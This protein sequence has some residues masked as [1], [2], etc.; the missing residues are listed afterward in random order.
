MNKYDQQWIARYFDDC[1]DREWERWEKSPADQVKFHI[2]RYYLEKYVS[3]GDH[4]LEIG[5]GSGRFTQTLVNLGAKILVADI[6]S[7]QL[8][9]NRRNAEEL[10][11]DH[12]VE[13]RIRIDMCNMSRLG[14]EDYDVVVCYGGPL[15]YV[16]ENRDN[17]LR[18]IMRVLKPS[19]IAMLSVMSLWGT[20]REYLG[21][22]L[23]IS[24][25]EN[26]E[27]IRTGDLHPDT[28]KD[29]RHRCHLFTAQ[30]LRLILEQNGFEI[31]CMSASN[32]LSSSRDASL[33][34]IQDD[35]VRWSHLLKTELVACAELGC[36]DIGTHII[37]VIR[38]RSG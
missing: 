20:I 7:G 11:F 35:P 5:A 10:S 36:L 18:E 33:I 2:H 37:S 28:Y 34:E 26:A 4:V 8:D 23:D 14:N 9:L 16:F 30:E 29:C 21:D 22:V 24:S 38:R 12:A 27:I 25:E 13:K 6:S 1:G 17:A 15:S 19:G 31:I 32:G 3:A